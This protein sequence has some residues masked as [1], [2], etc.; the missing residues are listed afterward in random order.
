LEAGPAEAAG[1]GSQAAPAAP[2]GLVERRRD[3]EEE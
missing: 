2:T 3:V 1:I